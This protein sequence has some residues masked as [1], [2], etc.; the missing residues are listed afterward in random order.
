ML[1]VAVLAS[2]ADV[3]ASGDPWAAFERPWFE[4]I[5]VEQ[6]LPDPVA[7]AI[8]QD[9]RG[10]MWFGT[11]NG[12]VRYDGFRMQT[13]HRDDRN[14]HSL[15]DDYVRAL[16]ALPDG[17]LLIGTSSGGVTRLDL[18]D[19]TFHAYPLVE[20]GATAGKIYAISAD[21]ERGAWIAAEQGLFHYDLSD[22]HLQRVETGKTSSR[23]NFSVHQD[24][25]GNVW[26]GNNN[27]LLVRMAGQSEFSPVATTSAAAS[28]I[29]VLRD[30][31]WTIQEDRAGRLWIGG[32]QAGAAY[33]GPDGRW[34]GVPG[35]NRSGDHAQLPTVRD[36][37]EV[38]EQMWIATDGGGIVAWRPGTASIAHIRHDNGVASSLPADSV[39]SLSM[40]A[41]GMVWAATDL[42]IARYDPLAQQA[43]SL[44]PSSDT[45]H[46]PASGNVRA[47]FVDR[48]GRI[49]LG[50]SAGQ[51]DVIDLDAG[52][53]RHLRLTGDQTHR[54]VLSFAED[55]SGGIWA[56]TL[57]LAHIDADSFVIHDSV[58][59]QLDG[60][61]VLSLLPVGDDLI[62]TTYEGVFRY[63]TVHG[64]M[65]HIEH[66]RDD[67]SSLASNVVRKA[68]R[69][70]DSLW[71]LTGHGISIARDPGQ[72]GSFLNLQ[73]D[74][75]D[76]ASLPQSM[77]TSATLDTRGRLWIGTYGG[78]AM[79][80]T[81][82]RKPL[83]F[84]TLDTDS[85]LPGNRVN[86]VQVDSAG[87]IWVSTSMGI[88][89][90]DGETLEVRTLGP[91]DGSRLTSYIYPAAA[92]TQRGE[93]LFGGIGGLTVVRTTRPAAPLPAASLA[94]TRI[95]IDGEETLFRQLVG[96]DGVIHM[97]HGK[98]LRIGFALLDYRP[99]T[100][101]Y[102][103]RMEGFDDIWTPIAKGSLPGATYTNLPHGKYVLKLRAQT[104]GMYPHT[105][106][107]SVP[108]EITPRWYETIPAQ[109]A[110]LLLLLMVVIA[111]IQLRTA[112]LRR[113][114]LDLKRRV[115]VRTAELRAANARL[116]RLAHTDELTGAANRRRFME[117]AEEICARQDASGACIA[118]FDLDHFK[119]INDHH[120]HLAGDATLRSVVAVM[121]RHCRE[122]DL[123]GRFGGEEFVLCLPGTSLDQGLAA[124]ERIR[125]AVAATPVQHE[126]Q[127][128]VVTTSIG[129]AVLRTGESLKG[130]LARADSA[131]YQ[132]KR[133]GRNR[134][135]VAD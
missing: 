119:R 123:L 30:E 76:P 135:V 131:L 117:L 50:L 78:L 72:S 84:R 100:T 114:A 115:D 116:D 82:A 45:L 19:G 1:L 70:D 106:E 89:R 44:Q 36:F 12:L 63:D 38:G 16:L 134:C 11:M 21:E 48:R 129:L 71:Y 91:R 113:Q 9:R 80:E 104:H 102:A 111:L 40:D 133:A 132:A 90:I 125:A 22:D 13:F 121:R 31:I 61:P 37:L 92:R 29:P 17:N 8:A 127:D 66:D 20:D 97:R 32:V 62:I 3:Q 35:F 15:S 96:A 51:I 33:R 120:G 2:A 10:L 4:A 69:L 88:S 6:G 56:G 60:K 68:M 34:R 101:T 67:P 25:H 47:V 49:W 81:P 14:H 65:T 122:Q 58:L 55:K 118:L 112:Y 128:I 52:T 53:F 46:S 86:A 5:G 41:S 18:A 130:W 95:F 24:R 79:T 108:I 7:T 109:I 42:G 39:R 105:V 94:V 110:A 103:Y 126:G 27:G 98:S 83:H 93:L 26:I 77:I 64:T 54:D 85:G 124:C 43:L 57:G 73:H 28:A 75:K 99:E 59:P 87:N 107:A 74:D 23:V